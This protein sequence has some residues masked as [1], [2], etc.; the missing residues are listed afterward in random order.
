[1]TDAFTTIEHA[2]RPEA[3][4]D[5]VAGLVDLHRQ[6]RML[7]RA[8]HPDLHG[9]SPRAGAAFQ[10]L[11]A[12]ADEAE[13]R[14]KAGI[15]G[16]NKPTP[17][18]GPTVIERRGRHY[19]VGDIVASGDI[20]DIFA[21][22]YQENKD[23]KRCVLKISRTMADNDLVENEAHVL[24]AM[25]PL[26]G[27]VSKG[28]RYLPR[29]IDSFKLPD[30]S[31]GPRQVNVLK[32]MDEMYSLEEVR[33]AYP[34]GIVLEDAVWIFHRM[35]EGLGYAHRA[36]YIHGAVLPPHIMVRPR[37]HGG[38]IVDWSYAVKPGDR[39][40]ALSSPWRP[41]Y[42]PEILNKGPATP[43]TDVYMAA[44]TVAWLIGGTKSIPVPRAD[45]PTKTRAAEQFA[46]FLGTCLAERPGARVDDA[47][48]VRKSCEEMMLRLYGPKKFHEFKMPGADR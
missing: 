43:S 36:G 11:T 22:T 28:V 26:S 45:D 12:L 35:L 25:E 17:H 10:K 40:R 1:M 32:R 48:A 41:F 39:V 42:A 29:I 9:N 44:Q 8:V 33:A 2:A 16:T 31:L 18:A 4:F 46:A 47:W 3:V 20:C 13:R 34:T 19:T 14:L 24:N 23:S 7:A 6:F 27:P 38:K 5:S 15:Y 30:A 37:D 21:A